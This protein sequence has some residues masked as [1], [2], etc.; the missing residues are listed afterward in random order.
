MEQATEWASLAKAG[1]SW[2][3]AATLLKAAEVFDEK[4]AALEADARDVRGDDPL[5]I[6]AEV[7]DIIKA[8]QPT[9]REQVLAQLAG[10]VH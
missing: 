6:L 9:A 3:A 5:A 10:Q 7:G 4:L 8:L 2:V 1:G